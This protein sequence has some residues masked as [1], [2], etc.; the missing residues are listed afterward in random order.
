[1]I[2]H[3]DID[4][5]FVSAHRTINKNLIG[6]AV[7]VGG[8]SNLS[9]FDN[10]S[11]IKK[12]IS[13]NNGAFVSS[14]LSK[15]SGTFEEY[16]KDANGRIRGIITTSSY[17]A[18]RYG[19]K[20]AMSVS[21][22]L[23]LCPHLIMIPPDYTLYHDLSQKLNKYLYTKTPHVEQFSI[24]EFFIDLS[25]YIADK[26]ILDFAKEL[27]EE[28]YNNFKLPISI[29]IANTKW[30]AKLATND[31]KPDGIKIIYQ[32]EV[33]EY[34]KDKPISAFPGIGKGYEKRLLVNGIRRLGQVRDKKELFYSWKKPGIQLYNRILGLDKER[35]LTRNS[36]KSIGIGRTFDPV[37][38]RNEI[39]R[40]IVILCRYL[41]FLVFKEKVTPQ[42]FFLKIR[43][44]YKSKSKDYINTNRLFNEKYFKDAILLLF[45]KID[46]HPTHY[47]IQLNLTVSNF[48]E[49]NNHSFNIFE[50]ENDKK[51][52]EL[53][54]KINDL[55]DKYGIDIIK[56]AI[57][58]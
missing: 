18:R 2:I 35:T 36:K 24:D 39:K 46:I 45:K 23:M 20:T 30:I 50:Y 8:R 47:I 27:K 6:K 11:N 19:V 15:N 29:G 53:A 42:T 41:S 10:K 16:Y 14:I 34:L 9:I 26:E 55:R 52:L 21:E 44:D 58:L 48:V 56:N 49:N 25:G 1:M 57:E 5:F 32:N 33:Y 12:V 3:L 7:A 37:Q 51:N 54:S 4:S 31:A 40:R 38:D 22:A 13:E 28:V 17:E 43:Y